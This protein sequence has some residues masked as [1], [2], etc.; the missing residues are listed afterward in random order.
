[1]NQDNGFL[2]IS[3]LQKE[4]E[5]KGA[6]LIGPEG[7]GKTTIIKYFIKTTEKKAIYINVKTKDSPFYESILKKLNTNISKQPNT[8]EKIVKKTLK[9][10]HIETIII[11]DIQNLLNIQNGDII[12]DYIND[13]KT[14]LNTCRIP[15]I[16]I[17]R[18]ESRK[19][20]TIDSQLKNSFNIFEILPF[21][22]DE[23]FR[24]F[25]EKYESNIPLRHPSNLKNSPLS[26]RIYE[27]SN[28]NIGKI[29]TII[30][31]S[32]ILAIENGEEK[33]TLPIINTLHK[34]GIF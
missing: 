30:K 20:F 19:L 3:I 29:T 4:K 10:K 34:Q 7:V 9:R 5:M 18:E 23:E 26:D 11:D 27:L 24:L 32:A 17:G 6:F 15:I 16:L 14:I 33:I 21:K 12:I 28:G 1:M 25:L 8:L 31:E 13:I 2:I 22:N